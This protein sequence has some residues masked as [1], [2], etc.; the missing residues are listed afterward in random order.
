M[1]TGTQVCR[2][3]S[4]RCTLP[5]VPNAK[6]PGIFPHPELRAGMG[7]NGAGSPGAEVGSQA[8][9]PEAPRGTAQPP[10]SASPEQPPATLIHKNWWAVV[11][12]SEPSG[13]LRQGS[14]QGVGWVE[15]PAGHLCW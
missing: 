3:G 15:P 8:A 13:L 12:C 1:L 10:S 7:H 11:G 6:G 9:N 2:V 5:S 14:T 4:G